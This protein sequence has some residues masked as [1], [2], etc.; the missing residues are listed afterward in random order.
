MDEVGFVVTH[1]SNEGLLAFSTV[2]G[3]DPRVVAGD[4]VW[5]GSDGRKVPGAVILP[6][7]HLTD[8][9]DRQKT[10]PY[11]KLW[12]DI[13]AENKEEAQ[14]AVRPGD[15]VTFATTLTEN[16]E[17]LFGRAL[18][19]RAG[20]ALLLNLL[21]D[22][23]WA[24]DTVFS[25]S[26]QEETGGAGA[27]TNGFAADP[28]AAIVVE[29]TTA[30]DMAGVDEDRL[31]CRQGKGPVL[32]FMDH[33]TIY[34]RTYCRWAFEEAERLGVPCQLERG[35]RRRQQRGQPARDARGRAQRR[36]L[37]AV[38]LHPRADGAFAQGGFRGGAAAF[39]GF[40]RAHRPSGAGRNVSRCSAR[41][42]GRRTR[43]PLMARR[44]AAAFWRRW[45]LTALRARCRSGG[46]MTFYWPAPATR[47]CSAARRRTPGKSRAFCAFW[48]AAC[49]SPRGRRS[50]FPFWKP[51][52]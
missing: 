14:K 22:E 48:G 8:R 6:P 10:I 46:A 42:S 12:I 39:E 29:S 28:Q 16:S 9:A 18:D 32:S 45:A 20:C 47:R 17:S 11:E 41:C 13:G 50:G 26:T 2:G 21:R 38:P 30:G 5:V 34:D 35:R 37:A 4:S 23:D 15:M 52:L 31:V 40:V 36:R 49:S 43:P 19:D 24:F 51:A 33:G 7:V 44:W 27:K 25:F 1:L 3:I